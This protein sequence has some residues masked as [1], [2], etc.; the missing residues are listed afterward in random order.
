MY[1][2]EWEPAMSADSVEE[3]VREFARLAQ[4]RADEQEKDINDVVHNLTHDSYL[5]KHMTS[6]VL[7]ELQELDGAYPDAFYN[8]A[9]NEH[10][11]EYAEQDENF[12][13]WYDYLYMFLAAGLEWAIL[14][15]IKESAANMDS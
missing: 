2:D 10:L 15:E 12:D 11:M 13:F 14:E 9:A 3:K 5:M 7:E 1:N 6:D 4:K 8:G